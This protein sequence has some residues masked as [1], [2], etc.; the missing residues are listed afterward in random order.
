MDAGVRVGLI[1]KEVITKKQLRE[2]AIIVGLFLPFFIGLLIPLLNGHSFRLWTIFIA[3]P[4]LIIG[5]ARPQSLL[6]PYKLWMKLGYFLGLIN[7]R[8]I[9]GLI[10]FIVLLPIS[11]FM[12][13]FGYD[14]LK[15]KKLSKNSYRETNENHKVDLTRIF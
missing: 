6:F 13:I 14:P 4:F 1:M 2:F 12:R 15:K 3:L 8:I 7:S 5:L 11:I 10:F 9:L